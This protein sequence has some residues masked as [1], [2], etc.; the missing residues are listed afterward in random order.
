MKRSRR[1]SG[2]LALAL[3]ALAPGL[4]LPVAARAAAQVTLQVRLQPER[5][6]V[7]ETA[8][9]IFEAR[10]GLSRLDL[11]PSFALENLEI[12]SGPSQA[13]EMRVENGL[14]SRTIRLSWKVRPLGVGPARAHSIHVELGGRVVAMPTQSIQVQQEPTGQNQAED[15]AP[16]GAEDPFERL[17]GPMPWQRPAAPRSPGPNEP[18][19]AFVRA[20]V[21]NDHPFVNQQVLYTIY[22]YSRIEVSAVNPLSTPE[23]R[24]FWAREIPLPE[25]LPTEIVSLGDVRYGRVPLLRR[26]LFPL[27]AGLHVFEPVRFQIATMQVPQG[28]PQSFFSPS[29]ARPMASDLSTAPLSLDVRPLPEGPAGYQGAVGPLALSA[30]L[31]PHVLRVGEAA[32]L[33]V[34]LAGSGNLQGLPAPHLALPAGLHSL[35]P[36]EGGTDRSNGTSLRTWTY[37]VIPDRAGTF[38]VDPPAVPYFDPTEAAFERAESPP[39]ALEAHAPAPV[40]AAA[41]APRPGRPARPSA[42]GTGGNAQGRRSAIDS[43][44]SALADPGALP[45]VIGGT[46]LLALISGLAWSKR[47]GPRSDETLRRFRAEVAAALTEERPRRTAALLESAWGHL[48]AARWQLDGP[49]PGSGWQSAAH[50]RG[51]APALKVELG[52]IAEDLHFLHTAPQLSSAEA[53]RDEIVERSLRLA[54]DLSRP[55]GHLLSSVLK[56][57]GFRVDRGTT[58]RPWLRSSE[59]SIPSGSSGGAPRDASAGGEPARRGLP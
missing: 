48:L 43:A 19:L 30:T 57:P 36:H 39:L 58:S 17:F 21:S 56:Q 10:T 15:E 6:G 38:H 13:D 53:L 37:V 11:R 7:G 29:F 22:L 41:G 2:H 25:R 45:W 14:F 8:T 33:Q 23:L 55:R 34:R 4:F 32:T 26:V 52:R 27:R 9:L 42:A 44:K 49:L 40:V 12:L 54:G 5:I 46:G 59:L 24:G 28:L 50:Q 1:T 47:S 18:P 16:F 51:L 3:F 31:E 35:P 20:E